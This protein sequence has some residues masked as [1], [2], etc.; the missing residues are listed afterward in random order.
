MY[1]NLYFFIQQVFGVEPFGFTKY[2]NTFGIL[3]ALAFFVAAYVLSKEFER[4][5]KE[6]LLQPLEESIVVG[7][8]ASVLDLLTNFIFGFIVGYKIIGIFLNST[9]GNPQEYI[10]SSEG[11]LAGGIAL[12]V[13]FTSLRY[14][15]KK[16]MALPKPETRKIK[17]WPHDRVGDITVYAAIFGFIGAKIFDNLE[18]WDRF[19][20]DP[21]G[22]LLSP[23]GL[24]FYGGLILASLFLLWYT[25]QK[26]ITTRHFI[27]AV[28]PALMIAYAVGR[29]GCHFAGDGD[30]GIFNSAYKVNEKNQIVEA[31]SWEFHQVL[32]DNQEYAKMLV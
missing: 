28:A 18:N 10:F 32:M 9:N 24:T 3:V 5:E 29:M 8:P 13:L 27:D 2:L 15:E 23:S 26:K 19:M 17:I 12:A 21:I 14:F 4:K 1:P 11:S 6:N 31:G 16:K 25:H 30:W 22:N 7:K 20:T